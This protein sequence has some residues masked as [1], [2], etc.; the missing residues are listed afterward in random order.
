MLE[1]FGLD[2]TLKLIQFQAAFHKARL[3]KAAERAAAQVHLCLPREVPQPGW[4]GLTCSQSTTGTKDKLILGGRRYASGTNTPSQTT[5]EQ[6]TE[7]LSKRGLP[8][9]AHRSLP[10]LGPSIG[11]WALLSARAWSALHPWVCAQGQLHGH[12]PAVSPCLPPLGQQLFRLN[13]P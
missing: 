3:L 5:K 2:E 7:G 4:E 9:L 11:L 12:L 8:R 6:S 10:T 1:H 13:S